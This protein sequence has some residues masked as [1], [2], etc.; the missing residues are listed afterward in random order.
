MRV[1]SVAL[2]V[3][4]FPCCAASPPLPTSDCDAQPSRAAVH[5]SAVPRSVP[6]TA[7]MSNARRGYHD[8]SFRPDVNV[9]SLPALLDAVHIG[10]IEPNHS[11]LLMADQH[12]CDAMA[13][14]TSFP[15]ASKDRERGA[16]WGKGEEGCECLAMLPSPRRWRAHGTQRGPHVRWHHISHR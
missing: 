2:P 3:R 6:Q 1:C 11:L 14:V 4:F 12:H 8:A 10:F 5:P 9:R 7:A 13:C 15:A 16:R